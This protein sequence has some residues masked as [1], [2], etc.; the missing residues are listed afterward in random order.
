[1]RA[2]KRQ[3]RQWASVLLSRNRM[4]GERKGIAGTPR[5]K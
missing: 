3:K 2:D 5:Y 4:R 1:M